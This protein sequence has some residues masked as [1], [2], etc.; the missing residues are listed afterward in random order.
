MIKNST[1]NGIDLL[2]LSMFQKLS[3]KPILNALKKKMT[4]I[5]CSGHLDIS[6][7][8]LVGAPFDV[9]FLSAHRL[10]CKG[11]LKA[12]WGNEEKSECKT[13]TGDWNVDIVPSDAKTMHDG[14]Y[15]FEIKA[16]HPAADSA[17]WLY[18]Q[19]QNAKHLFKS[20]LKGRLGLSAEAEVLLWNEKPCCKCLHVNLAVSCEAN[21]HERATR[22][23]KLAAQAIALYAVVPVRVA[24]SSAVTNAEKKVIIFTGQEV[25]E[26]AA[27]LAALISVNS[28]SGE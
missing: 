13:Q 4:D 3:V 26:K 16:H 10:K 28:G 8:V 20:S 12:F 27:G 25:L 15:G 2:G 18:L 22:I 5:T 14:E 24:A 9:P 6:A 17:G 1:K 21:V 11:V 23:R 19:A 7:E